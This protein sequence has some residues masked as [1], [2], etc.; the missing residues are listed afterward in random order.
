MMSRECHPVWEELHWGRVHKGQDVEEVIKSTNPVR[1]GRYGDFVSLDYQE[2]LCF[3]GVT[4]TAKNGRLA[5]AAAW[6]CT[7]D[8]V[9]FNEL[10]EE[11]WKAYSNAR[12]AHWPPI[13]KK[14]EQ[15]EQ[16]DLPNPVGM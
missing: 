8:R 9:F 14:R 12:E 4:V 7:W 10:T 13:R 2:G 3:T 1:V 11:D 5:S 6:S 16:A 15:A